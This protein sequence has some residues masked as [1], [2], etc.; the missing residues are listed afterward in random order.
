MEPLTYILVMLIIFLAAIIMGI[1]SFGFAMIAVPLLNLLLPLKFL[2]PVLI[3]YGVLIDIVLLLPI[4]KH[5][6]LKGMGYLVG[7]GILGVPIGTWLL[8]VVDESIMK[9]AVGVLII[10]SAWM[11]YSGLRVQ[12]KNEKLGNVIAG[13]TS[14]ILNG[15]LTMSGPPVIFF[16]SN[17]QLEKQVFRANL[18]FF[19]LVT[20]VFTV[21]V[22][23]TSG[24]ITPEVLNYAVTMSPSLLISS[25]GILIGSKIGTSM[26][27]TLFNR[28]SLLLFFIM[29]VMSIASAV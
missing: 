27:S 8:V 18:A 2:V 28:I 19:F 6:N 3:L 14:G 1:T 15:S 13:F 4:Y 21:P 22:M 29:G 25:A 11:L 9:I 24:L 20:T 26:N 5:L 17:Q 7:A 23:M 10:V 16:Y 12:I